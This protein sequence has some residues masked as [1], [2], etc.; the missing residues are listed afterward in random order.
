MTDTLAALLN[1][2]DNAKRQFSTAGSSALD[3][4]RIRETLLGEC[5]YELAK[6]QGVVLQRPLSI[7]A[8]GEFRLV[9][10]K[11]ATSNPNVEGTAPFGAV[12]GGLLTRHFART[13]THPGSISAANGWCMLNHFD[14][15]RMVREYA[16]MQPA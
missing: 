9:A 14:A 11:S 1:D 4:A 2:L 5:L 10:L 13:G 6:E 16:D 12:L 3:F 8:R 7:D 15:E